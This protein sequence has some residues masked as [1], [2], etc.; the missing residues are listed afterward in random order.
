MP[1]SFVRLGGSPASIAARSNVALPSRAVSNIRCAKSIVSGGSSDAV[2]VSEFC[3]CDWRLSISASNDH[4][5][6]VRRNGEQARE[7]KAAGLGLCSEVTYTSIFDFVAVDRQIST[8]RPGS[9]V[10]P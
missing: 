10:T 8:T 4:A 2:R 5:D 7:I 9:P 6:H 3:Q 1:F